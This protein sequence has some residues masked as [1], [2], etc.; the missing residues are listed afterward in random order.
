MDPPDPP[1][2]PAIDSARV[3]AFANTA[4]NRMQGLL[5]TVF[6]GQHLGTPNPFLLPTLGAPGPATAQR[7]A[8]A[9]SACAPVQTGVDTNGVAIDSDLDGVPDDNTVDF[10]AGCSVL[11]G[12]LEYTFSGKY[13]LRDTGGGLIDWDYTTTAL[14]AKVRDTLSGDFIRQQVSGSESAHFTTLHA[15]HQMDVILEVEGRSGADSSHVT[16]RTLT[17]STYDPAGGSGFQLH[18][19]LPQGTFGLAAELTFRDLAVAADSQRFVITTPT[20][21]HIAFACDSGID[22][23]VM[24]GLFEGDERVGFQFTWPGCGAPF[25]QVFGTTP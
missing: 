3:F 9:A 19:S 11:D 5:H 16:L 7:L 18:G 15:A 23:G 13:R 1:P 21:I 12:G 4:E 17:A 22:A 2:L 25:I 6:G 24:E 14:A 10:G 8:A 20:P